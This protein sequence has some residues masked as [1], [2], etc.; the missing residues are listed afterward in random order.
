[1][2]ASL[3]CSLSITVDIYCA[4]SITYN[5]YGSGYFYDDILCKWQLNG[6]DYSDKIS[7]AYND[8]ITMGFILD[9][10]PSDYIQSI[11]LSIQNAYLQVVS[12][13]KYIFNI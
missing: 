10:Y 12:C 1:V 11:D 8:C 7:T 4:E 6:F 5:W 3:S 2:I 13:G 9:F